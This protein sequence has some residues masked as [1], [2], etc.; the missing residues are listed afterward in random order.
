MDGPFPSVRPCLR[1]MPTVDCQEEERDIPRISVEYG[2]N[3]L[4]SL[5]R[6]DWC[7]RGLRLPISFLCDIL[8]IIHDTLLTFYFDAEVF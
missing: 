1:I 7:Y 6:F 3:S 4:V 5:R 8:V 2:L